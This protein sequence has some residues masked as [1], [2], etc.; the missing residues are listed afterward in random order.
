MIKN[1]NPIQPVSGT[2]APRYAGPL[3]FARIPELRDVESC[4]EAITGV[5]L[6]LKRQL[7]KLRKQHQIY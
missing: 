5:P 4:D 2:K 7:N 6:I 1:K 3:T